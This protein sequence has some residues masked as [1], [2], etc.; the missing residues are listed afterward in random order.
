MTKTIGDFIEW[1]GSPTVSDE[2]YKELF[3]VPLPPIW[4]DSRKIE[5]GDIFLALAGELR[6]GHDYV[7]TALNNGARCALV[8]QGGMAQIPNELHHRCIVVEDPLASVQQAAFQFRQ[9]LSIPVITIA[10]SNGK[11]T[12]AHYLT[13]VLSTELRVGGTVGNW[14]NHIGVPLSILRLSGDEDVAIFEVGANHVGEIADL[15]EI[16]QP[17]IGVITNIGY[18]HVGL[19]GGI[20]KTAG[21]KFELARFLAIKGGELYI[22]SDD[23]R[24][25]K[26]ATIDFPTAQLFGSTEKAVVKACDIS[27]SPQ[28]NYSFTLNNHRYTLATAGIHSIYSLLP[29]LAIAQKLGLSQTSIDRGVAALRPASMRGGIEVVA[30][31][32]YI[33]DCYNANPSSMKTAAKLLQDIPNSSRKIAVLGDMKEL[34][35]YDAELHAEVG[36]LYGELGIDTIIAIGHSALTLIKGALSVGFAKEKCHSFPSVQEATAFFARFVQVGDLVLLKGSRG[37]ALET[38]FEEMKSGAHE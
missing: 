34:G 10:G 9:T 23:Q 38:L 12:T 32:S 18:A 13:T 8:A 30:G 31:V 6:D 36:A 5:E 1:L 20:E 3:A 4:M 24:S 26:Q 15:V 35:S 25:V 22:N 37:I 21:A 16:I 28:G 33:L 7:E 27:C 29:A 14:N 19:F 17:T 2:L 11:T